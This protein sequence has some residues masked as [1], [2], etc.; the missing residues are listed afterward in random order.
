[1]ASQVEQRLYLHLA[2]RSLVRLPPRSQA[3]LSHFPPWSAF[4]ISVCPAG[5]LKLE[6]CRK[7]ASKP[8]PATATRPAAPPPPRADPAEHR[9]AGAR[10]PLPPSR[11]T[12]TRPAPAP[13][14]MGSHWTLTAAPVPF[15]L[16]AP[17]AA[18][19]LAV[20]AML[21]APAAQAMEV[22]QLAEVGGVW[23]WRDGA[24]AGSAAADP[25]FFL[26]SSPFLTPPG[27]APH[28]HPGLVCHLRHVLHVARARRVGP[29]GALSAERPCRSAVGELERGG[30]V[31]AGARA[32]RVTRAAA[33]DSLGWVGGG[34]DGGASRV[35]ERVR[36]PTP[37]LHPA[38]GHGAPGRSANL[39][40]PLSAWHRSRNSRGGRAS[41]SAEP[42]LS[43]I[44][45]A[46]RP[47]TE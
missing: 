31:G 2:H 25:S 16:A 9:A 47:P 43:H 37:P 28:R 29:V 15:F 3:H 36:R 23:G 42:L 20:A 34:G 14:A 4:R 7:A 21:A 12:R 10:A 40:A 39:A 32:R 22:M 8:P 24:R 46:S 33:P 45:H 26:T 27:R 5:H 30:E 17:A 13:G 35:A 11:A 1:M 38:A 6:S 18:A 19:A 44:G 41:A